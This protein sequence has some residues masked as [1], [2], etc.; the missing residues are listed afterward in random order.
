MSF[1]RIF[2][3][4]HYAQNNNPNFG[5][6]F[7]TYLPSTVKVQQDFDLVSFIVQYYPLYPSIPNRCKTMSIVF[8]VGVFVQCTINIDPYKDYSSIPNGIE[9]LVEDIN[10]LIE[11]EVPLT[12]PAG[13]NIVTLDSGAGSTW[14]NK[15]K[16]DVGAVAGVAGFICGFEDSGVPGAPESQRNCLYHRMG[17]TGQETNGNYTGVI[18]TSTFVTSIESF[19]IPSILRTSALYVSC[20][21][22]HDGLSVSGRTSIM[23]QIGIPM[24]M[25]AGDVLTDK[26]SYDFSNVISVGD[27]IQAVTIELLDDDF[28]M[29][30]MTPLAFIGLE[31]HVGIEEKRPTTAPQVRH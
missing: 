3:N 18:G 6:S 22:V 27:S 21:T 9:V 25:T 5:G 8:S 17:F 30:E 28:E 29:L 11:A 15:I 13:S 31:I 20:P 14:T 16:I 7:T 19:G 2:L 10:T 1:S 12:T 4:S 24:D 26:T 23:K